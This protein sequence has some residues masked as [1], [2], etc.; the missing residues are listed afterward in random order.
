M[1]RLIVRLAVVLA[2]AVV[3][4]AGLCAEPGAAPAVTSPADASPADASPLA[5]AP[6]DPARL[7]AAD[8]ARLPFVEKPALSPTGERIA[9]LFGLQG[10]QVLKVLALATTQ[11]P[12][13]TVRLPEQTEADWIRW[14][15][16]DFVLVG[17]RAQQNVEG[18]RWYIS[19]IISVDLRKH[20]L[21]KLLW[22]MGGQSA[23]LVWTPAD[24]SHSVLIAAQNSIYSN[25][26]E[27]WPAVY[28]VDIESGRS[29][30]VLDG[31]D[32]VMEWM[33]DATGRVRAGAASGAGGL[34][35]RLIYRTERSDTFRTLGR[36]DE[37]KRESLLQ[38]FAFV[39]GSDHA[40]VYLGQDNGRQGIFEFDLARGKDVAKLAESPVGR[41]ITSTVLAEDGQT[42]LGFYTSDP[43]RPVV[44]LEPGLAETQAA[45]EKAI[46]TRRAEII[47]FNRDRSRMLVKIDRADSPG[48]LYYYDT[49]DGRLRFLSNFNEAMGTRPLSPLQLVQYTARDGTPIEAVLTLPRG[50]PAKN[51]PIVVMP[52]GGP[53][54]QDTANYDFLLQFIASR[55]Y[56]VLQPNFRGSTGYGAEFERKGEG[57]MGLA[58]QDDITDGL[59]W[60]TAQGIA[61]PARAC[62][63]GWSYGGYAAMWG[64][65]KDPAQYR[66]AVSIAGISSLRRDAASFADNLNGRANRMG[67][68]R[69][70]PDPEA[71]SPANAA[72][73]ITAPLLLIHGKKDVRVD[74]DQSQLMYNRMS[75][76]KKPVEFVPVA[77]ADHYF[78]R[79]AD[80]ATLLAAVEAFLMK[81]NPATP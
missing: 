32:G 55:D 56:A 3:T 1:A 66:C 44:W 67:W 16:D 36:A 8:F 40:L 73:R 15:G 70:A 63:V 58:M 23:D 54:S 30:R 18:N 13:F 37:R 27:F 49:A 21:V 60:A 75:A 34:S 39:P 64:I 6:F 9:G 41:E 72:A 76:A 19:R 33:A 74:F 47:S 59:R 46:G 22:T 48:A 68:G 81:N 80:R 14:V 29:S 17:L 2:G 79:E 71:V 24:G 20:A 25:Y 4:S 12:L 38:P 35:S 57:Q 50:R 51:L 62:I 42:L 77:Q 65:A 69:M 52:H 78:T 31:Q 43:I 11:E 10:Q 7:T 61:D 28:R 45:F 5:A 26:A 53:W